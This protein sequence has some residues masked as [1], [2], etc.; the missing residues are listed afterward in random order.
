M[1]LLQTPSTQSSG[2]PSKDLG[3][4]GSLA[5]PDFQSFTPKWF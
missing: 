2:T 1:F 5:F 3:T 4:C